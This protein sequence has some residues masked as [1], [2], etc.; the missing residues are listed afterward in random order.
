MKQ[1]LT[2][3]V[4]LAFLISLPLWIVMGNYLLAAF[5]AILFSFFIGMVRALITL[6]KNSKDQ[7]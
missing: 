3:P 2:K 7:S 1:L 6:S 4:L 5:S